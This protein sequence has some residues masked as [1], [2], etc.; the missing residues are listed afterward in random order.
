MADEGRSPKFVDQ[1][2]DTV[3][4]DQGYRTSQGTVVDWYDARVKYWLA[5][6]NASRRITNLAVS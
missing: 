2:Y 6:E 4:P 3:L 1:G 5:G